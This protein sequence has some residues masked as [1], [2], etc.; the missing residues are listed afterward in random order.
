M[1]ETFLKCPWPC[2]SELHTHTA[3][4]SLILQHYDPALRFHY[5]SGQKM[6]KVVGCHD[7]DMRNDKMK[8]KLHKCLWICSKIQNMESTYFDYFC[9]N[10]QKL[11]SIY[12]YCQ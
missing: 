2:I 9:Y 11:F 5:F 10:G 6:D 8:N 12:V 3:T 1:V 4:H 7:S